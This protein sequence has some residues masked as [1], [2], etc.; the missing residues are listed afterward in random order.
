MLEEEP[1]GGGFPNSRIKRWTAASAALLL[2]AGTLVATT[3]ALNHYRNAIHKDN[4]GGNYPQTVNFEAQPLLTCMACVTQGRSWQMGTCNPT[5][6]CLLMDQACYEDAKGCQ[7]WEEQAEAENVCKVQKD[8]ANCISSNQLCAWSEDAGC[9][10]L[11]DDWGLE[12][13][14][15]KHG[16]TCSPAPKAAEITTTFEPKHGSSSDG[17]LKPSREPLAECM[18]CV[19]MGKSWQVGECN[20][21]SECLIADAG[22]FQDASGCRRWHEEHEASLKCKAQKDCSSCLRSNNLCMW[23]PHSGCFIGSGF[24]WAPPEDVF[25][26][27]GKCPE[28]EA[29]PLEREEV[30]KE[31]V[32]MDVKGI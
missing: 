4:S 27:G 6:E 2:C 18:A 32:L 8:C 21:S 3:S 28:D 5:Q 17:F 11:A 23:H 14:V 31:H 7:Q 1:A 13:L 12:H 16:E 30:L 25:Q 19:G 10:M 20:P 29:T 24:F 9:L 22:C 15:V 26:H